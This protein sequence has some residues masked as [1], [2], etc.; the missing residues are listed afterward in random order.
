MAIR[1]RR[2]PRSLIP[3]VTVLWWSDG[4]DGFSTIS[5]GVRYAQRMCGSAKGEGEVS[6]Q[7]GFPHMGFADRALA[8]EERLRRAGVDADDVVAFKCGRPLLTYRI[9]DGRRIESYAR[10]KDPTPTREVAAQRG[11]AAALLAREREPG[12]RAALRHWVDELDWILEYRRA[13][14]TPRGR[15]GLGRPRR[16]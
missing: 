14:P 7:V 16:R 13:Q 1:R 3:S 10:E 5:A 12:A 11:R 8:A 6:A 4:N 2:V 9:E 15:E